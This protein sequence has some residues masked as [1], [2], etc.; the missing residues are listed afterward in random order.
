MSVNNAEIYEPPALM[1]DVSFESQCEETLKINYFG[2]KKVVKTFKEMMNTG[3]RIV[4]CSSHLGKVLNRE[5]KHLE[6][7][8]YFKGRR[9]SVS[10]Y[11]SNMRGMG[12]TLDIRTFQ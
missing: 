6:I 11:I 4:N 9:R 5:E 2:V 12:S 1:D 3:G 10:Y 8:S 7:F